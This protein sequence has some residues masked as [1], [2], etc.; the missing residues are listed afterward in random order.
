MACRCLSAVNAFQ[1]QMPFRSCA[2]HVPQSCLQRSYEHGVHVQLYY[3]TPEARGQA[4]EQAGT[5]SPTA[6]ASADDAMGPPVAALEP[7]MDAVRMGAAPEQASADNDIS[8]GGS[9][10]ACPE[11][12]LWKQA[13]AAARHAPGTESRAPFSIDARTLCHDQRGMMCSSLPHLL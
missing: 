6:G 12:L 9:S 5:R 1:H 3:C 10:G 4:P 7:R 11:R 13:D 2:L 8:A